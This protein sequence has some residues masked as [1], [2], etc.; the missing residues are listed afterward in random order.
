MVKRVSQCVDGS[1]VLHADLYK[2]ETTYLGGGGGGYLDNP[3]PYKCVN[4]VQA[5]SA[6]CLTS[7]RQALLGPF[8]LT[9]LGFMGNTLG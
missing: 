2:L 7:S 5:H 3:K 9:P 4:L 8:G 6:V 1:K